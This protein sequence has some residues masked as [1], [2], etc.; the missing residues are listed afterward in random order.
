MRRVH[1]HSRILKDTTAHGRR[2]LAGEMANHG[3]AW[4]RMLELMLDLEA[5]FGR[6]LESTGSSWKPDLP[7]QSREEA[8]RAWSWLH[9]QHAKDVHVAARELV[10]TG[11]M[12]DACSEV[13]YF[14]SFRF[15]AAIRHLGM[16]VTIRGDRPVSMIPFPQVE[17]S[18]YAEWLLTEWAD[19]HAIGVAYPEHAVV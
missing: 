4:D 9:G 5:A 14:L 3:A 19:D 10:R 7:I 16:A 17:M 8:S 11:G 13:L 18:D 12:G 15:D 6:T 2:P 1:D